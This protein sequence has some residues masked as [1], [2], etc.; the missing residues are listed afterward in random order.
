M[1]LTLLFSSKNVVA[2]NEAIPLDHF[3]VKRQNGSIFRKFFSKF[4]VGLST[5]YGRT[6]FKHELDGFGIYQPAGVAPSIFVI[7]SPASVT[8]RYSNWTSDLTSDTAPTDPA[9]FTVASDTTSLGFKGKAF[10]VPLKLTLSYEFKRYRVGVG[11][12]YEYMNIGDFTPTNYGDRISGYSLPKSGGLMR[13]YFFAGGVSF[14]R[15]QDF[16]FTADIELGDFKPKSNINNTII[17]KGMYY[18]LGVTVERDLS[19]YFRLFVRPSYELKNY[20]IGVP[21]N[22]RSITH[23]MNAFYLNFGASYR[24]PELR[25]CFH[26]QCQAQINHAHGNRE[27]RSRMHP[28]YKKQNPGY[29]ENNKV[30]I[31]YKGKNKRKLNPY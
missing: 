28:I 14:Y 11:Y 31:K 24:L 21:E 18:N 6:S 8:T 20:S 17:E 23:S 30:L 27:Y 19:E 16:L 2:Q 3:Y 5:G 10:N 7:T 1:T 13:R 9:A 4:R 26:K 22:S 25:K 29:G 12:S 15:I